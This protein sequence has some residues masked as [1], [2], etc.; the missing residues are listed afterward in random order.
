MHEVKLL[1]I[2]SIVSCFALVLILRP[3]IKNKKISIVIALG[4]LVSITL[5]YLFFGG[6]IDLKSYNIALEKQKRAEEILLSIK[7][8]DELINKLKAHL[9]KNPDSAKG[10]YLL[11]RIY[12]SQ[13]KFD[14]AKNSLAKAHK[15]APND[16]Q[17]TIN[18]AKSLL[19]TNNIK[20]RTLLINILK[21]NPNQQDVLAILAI[22]A[23]NKKSFQEAIDLW[24]RLLLIIP[25]NSSESNEIRHY[26]ANAHLKLI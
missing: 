1:I 12:I 6:F 8:E 3:F 24:Q 21:Q 13:N 5:V 19:E 22:D 7:S 26:I 14:L 17:I 15:I 9:A 11:G 10:F 18:Y 2:L 25:E 23:Y 4:L 16:L 20:G